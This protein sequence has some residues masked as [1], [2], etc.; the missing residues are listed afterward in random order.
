MLVCYGRFEI[1]NNIQ[2]FMSQDAGTSLLTERRRIVRKRL[3]CLFATI[4]YSVIFFV[5]QWNT[6]FHVRRD[7]LADDYDG[8]QNV[9]NI[10]WTYQALFK[11]HQSPWFT[12]FLH[13]PRGISLQGHTLTIANGLLALPF[14]RWFSLPQI[15]NGLLIFSFVA[16]GVFGF[17]L[18]LE[19]TRD[20]PG[21]LLSGCIMTFC[22]YH[23]A[24]AQG[25]LQLIA[26]EGIPLFLLLWIRLLNEPSLLRAFAS[27]VALCFVLACDYYY[28]MFSTIAA[29]IFGIAI[30]RNSF[31]SNGKRIRAV[32]L[33][34]LLVMAVASPLLFGLY[35]ISREGPMIGIHSSSLYSMDLLAP[36]IPGGIGV[37][38][39]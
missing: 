37:S 5:F 12:R 2:R 30:C 6:L 18:A 10:W 8:L 19:M 14:H 35:Q 3:L 33:F 36:F 25:H 15:Y 27:A 21:S 7:L 34:G 22:E 32:G 17:F 26:M 38:R 24:H 28:F 16:T 13:Y 11:L 20:I 1:G 9:W 23:F 31:S 29:I 4:F 39:D